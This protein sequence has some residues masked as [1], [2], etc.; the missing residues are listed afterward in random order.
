MKKNRKKLYW[1]MGG[2]A[3]GKSTLRRALCS[4]FGTQDAELVQEEGIEYT[5]FGR[6][7]CPGK[8]IKSD[9]CDG[10]DSSFGKLKKE[11]GIRTTERCVREHEIVVLEGSQTT[12]Q[13]VKPLVDICSRNNCDFYMVLMDCR[14]WENY[15]RLKKRILA[16]GG[17]DADVT[18]DRLNSV[19]AKNNQYKGIF[20][21]SQE[22][23]GINF[24]RINTEGMEVEEEIMQLIEES[25]LC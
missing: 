10:L 14:L 9:G 13:W 17:S 15:K 7:A 12:L 18:D 20:T 1:I 16:R 6:V 2:M 11:G 8:C 24:I 3:S 19:R 25:R 4:V 23:E 22:V 21:K 5:S